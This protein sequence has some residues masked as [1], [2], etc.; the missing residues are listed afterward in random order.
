[1][2]LKAKAACGDDDDSPS[3]TGLCSDFYVFKWVL[4]VLPPF[5]CFRSVPT[6][7]RGRGGYWLSDGRSVQRSRKTQS[8]A[9]VKRPLLKI[10]AE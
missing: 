4:T 7:Q 9:K 8:N 6:F 2:R 1:M 3:H 10:L 5:L